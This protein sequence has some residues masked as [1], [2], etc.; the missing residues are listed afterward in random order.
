MPV[1]VESCS[2]WAGPEL[3]AA[4][5]QLSTHVARSTAEASVVVRVDTTRGSGRGRAHLLA[6]NMR[7]VGSRSLR[8]LLLLNVTE[9][10]RQHTGLLLLRDVRPTA[11][12]SVLLRMVGLLGIL[13]TSSGMTALTSSRRS[14]LSTGR[15]A[16]RSVVVGRAGCRSSSWRALSGRLRLRIL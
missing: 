11:V 10:L 1:R 15:G 4:R 13:L 8:V 5:I 3:V 12:V 6:R 14:S 7:L 2:K 9:S 16:R